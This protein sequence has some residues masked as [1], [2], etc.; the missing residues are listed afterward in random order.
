MARA[1]IWA[2][3]I[4]H[5]CSQSLDP[6]YCPLPLSQANSWE[7]FSY[8]PGSAQVVVCWSQVVVYSAPAITAWLLLAAPMLLA[9]A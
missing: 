6:P 7:A 9:L 4:E 5:H 8:L 2:R 3:G 1:I